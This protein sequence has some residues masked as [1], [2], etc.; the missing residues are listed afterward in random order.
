MEDK[1]VLTREELKKCVS[2][3]VKDYISSVIKESVINALSE[4][5]K[6]K[7]AD[8]DFISMVYETGCL[9]AEHKIFCESLIARNAPSEVM[10][11]YIMQ[12]LQTV[13]NC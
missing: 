2:D 9:P 3:S 10:K 8:L 12:A 7:Q 5:C 6:A 11:N 4:F 13:S 1:I